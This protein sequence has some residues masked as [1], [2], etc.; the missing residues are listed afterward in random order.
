MEKIKIEGSTVDFFKGKENELTTY[1]FDT[2]PD[3][4]K[5][6]T[7]KASLKTDRGGTAHGSHAIRKTKTQRIRSDI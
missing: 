5:A 2:L 1:Q 6:L 3:H 7:M 4:E